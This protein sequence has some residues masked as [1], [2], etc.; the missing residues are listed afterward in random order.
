MQQKPLQFTEIAR[1]KVHLV[2]ESSNTEIAF[3]GRLNFADSSPI[4]QIPFIKL[5]WNEFAFSIAPASKKKSSPFLE[6]VN[7]TVPQGGSCNVYL[8]PSKNPLLLV[9]EGI[10]DFRVEMRHK[11]K[12]IGTIFEFLEGICA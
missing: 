10:L 9:H 7:F 8:A 6:L 11:A 12:G 5:S 3:K 4:S 2:T 1:H